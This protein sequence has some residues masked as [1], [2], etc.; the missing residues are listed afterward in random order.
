MG[1]DNERKG[2]GDGVGPR[3]VPQSAL[4]CRLPTTES[5]THTI[6]CTEMRCAAPDLL[7]VVPR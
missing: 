4:G 6:M 5:E 1:I 2:T 7:S 3:N